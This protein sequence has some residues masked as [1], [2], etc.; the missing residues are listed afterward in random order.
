MNKKQMNEAINKKLGYELLQ[1]WESFSYREI[2]KIYRD[3]VINDY[4]VYYDGYQCIITP[5]CYM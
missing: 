4:V 5:P 2:Q 3:I 1:A